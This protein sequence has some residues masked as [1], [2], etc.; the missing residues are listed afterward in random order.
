MNLWVWEVY[1]IYFFSTGVEGAQQFSAQLLAGYASVVV[2]AGFRLPHSRCCPLEFKHRHVLPLRRHTSGAGQMFIYGSPQLA[3]V[4]RPTLAFL[5]VTM[6]L[7]AEALTGR[8]LNK[9][10]QFS[11]ISF[12][13]FDLGQVKTQEPRQSI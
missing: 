11:D 6:L 7:L 5:D 12:R 4:V 10:T 3:G 2:R 9:A 8:K 1:F 13:Y